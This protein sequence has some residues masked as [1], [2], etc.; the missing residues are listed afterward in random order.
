MELATVLLNRYYSLT[1]LSEV[2]RIVMGKLMS[3]YI[4]QWLTLLH[5]VLHPRHELVYFKNVGWQ[6]DWIKMAEA[7]MH[8]EFNRSYSSIQTS[9]QSTEKSPD[10]NKVCTTGLLL[11]RI[12]CCEGSLSIF[13]IIYLHL[14]HQSCKKSG[15][16]WI[17]TSLQTLNTSTTLSNGGMTTTTRIQPYPGWLLITFQSQVCAMFHP[18]E[19]SN[20][21]Y[22][23]HVNQC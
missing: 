7:L 6:T 12:S 1:D 8:E 15:R 4:Y 11:F 18:Y 5:T 14:H 10:V 3:L 9:T 20:E 21:H 13:L 16:N 2:Y 22:H 23:S 17:A 19:L